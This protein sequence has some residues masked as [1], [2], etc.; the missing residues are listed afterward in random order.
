MSILYIDTR[1]NKEIVV[2]LEK[3]DK[4]FELKSD[5]LNLKAQATLPLIDKILKE[6]NLTPADINEIKVERGPGSFTGL[7]VGI[8]IANALGF[9]NNIKINGKKVS[10]IET[11]QY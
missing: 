5:A 3:G 2:R 6:A 7:R 11:P 1:N 4:V 9:A 8:S 10:E